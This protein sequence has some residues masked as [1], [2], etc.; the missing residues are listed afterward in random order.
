MTEGSSRKK[1]KHERTFELIGAFKMG[2]CRFAP[3]QINMLIFVSLT[4]APAVNHKIEQ[5][6]RCQL[7]NDVGCIDPRRCH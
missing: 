6:K 3:K 4:P 7:I 5:A 2:R 1:A